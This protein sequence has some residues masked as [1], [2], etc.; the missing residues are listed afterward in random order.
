MAGVYQ[1]FVVDQEGTPFGEIGNAAVSRVSTVLNDSGSCVF[2]LATTD[3]DAAL[4]MFGRE[5][6]VW[7]DE[8]VVFWGPLVRRDVGLHETTWQ[9]AGL[10]WY[11][12]H[13]FMGTA[14]RNNQ[15]VNGSF[16]AGEDDWL[17]TAGVDHE[18]DTA[19]HIEVPTGQSLKLTGPTTDHTEYA[20][21][22]WTHPVGGHPLGDYMT[23]SAQVLI[24]AGP[25]YLG[26]A[27]D[28]R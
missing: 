24:P 18:I 9:C 13:R 26:P 21:Q 27:L 11:F 12:A 2:T 1:V 16:E 4:L 23:A 7:R 10:L 6:Q 19:T 25:V 8:E 3:P 5:V 15:L 22:Y 28:D 14:D 17:F 20:Y